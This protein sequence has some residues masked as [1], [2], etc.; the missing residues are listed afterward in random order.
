L[1]LKK[2]DDAFG[3][4]TALADTQ[5][6]APALN[7]LGVVQLRRGAPPATGLPSY[8]FNRAR[9][10]D[11]ADPDY[12]FNLGYAYWE[13]RDPQGA[14]YWLREAVRRTPADGDAHFVLA[15][16]LGMAGNTAEAAR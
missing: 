9:E 8:F 16:A 10:L 11:P 5:P 15:A 2:Y 1:T 13:N 12:L 3:T 6:T 14:M 7:N 4:F